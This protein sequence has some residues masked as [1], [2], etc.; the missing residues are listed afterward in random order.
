[1][2]KVCALAG[3]S[4]NPRRDVPLSIAYTLA[5]LSVTYVLAALALSG[6]VP[7][8]GSLDGSSF[9]LAFAA[10]GWGWACQVCV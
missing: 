7:V 4:F 2:F 5:I 9:V 8:D 3:E 6:M 1:F 10:R